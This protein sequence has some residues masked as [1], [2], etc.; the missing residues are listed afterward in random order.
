M[1]VDCLWRE[2][3]Q[4]CISSSWEILAVCLYHLQEWSSQDKL[5]T[6]IYPSLTRMQQPLKSKM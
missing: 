6:F 3:G 1:K 4:T 5:P 2:M